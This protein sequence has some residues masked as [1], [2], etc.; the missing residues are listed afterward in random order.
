MSFE[1]ACTYPVPSKS[2]SA[3]SHVWLDSLKMRYGRVVLLIE[4]SKRESQVDS[5]PP[6]Q[7]IDNAEAVLGTVAG[8]Y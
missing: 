8:E 4:C 1:T 6:D 3:L 7:G 2:P 5:H